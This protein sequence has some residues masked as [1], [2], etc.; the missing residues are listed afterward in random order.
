MTL[1]LSNLKAFA[2]DK[3]NVTQ[4]LKAVYGKIETEKKEKKIAIDLTLF[5]FFHNVFECY[6]LSV[7]QS[8]DVW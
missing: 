2:D 8:R 1:D 5:S 7:F 6:S 3:V 4:I